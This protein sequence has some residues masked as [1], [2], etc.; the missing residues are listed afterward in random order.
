MAEAG[1]AS[2][3]PV[4][5]FVRIGLLLFTVA[6]W[7]TGFS[8]FVIGIWSAVELNKYDDLPSNNY[9]SAAIV[10]IVIGLIIA[11]V[12]ICGC[13]GALRKNVCLLKTFALFLGLVVLCEVCVAVA[14]YAYRSKVKNALSTGLRETMK[15]YKNGGVLQN[16]WDQMQ[17]NFECCGNRNYTDWFHVL[18][19]KNAVVDSANSTVPKSC[20]WK[21]QDNC[22]SYLHVQNQTEVAKWIYMEGCYDHITNF[23]QSKFALLASG[24][25]GVAL[26]QIIGVACSGCLWTHIQRKT[27]YELV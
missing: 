13:C 4:M 21:Q 16:S 19:S 6:F 15:E 2:V 20:C 9:N 17:E 8:L 12:G 26:V 24:A 10:L 11:C 23:F 27:N 1:S 22:N 5:Q 25:L 14:G 3:S 18:W 7:I